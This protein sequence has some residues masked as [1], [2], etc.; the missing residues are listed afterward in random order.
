MNQFPQYADRP[1]RP[2]DQYELVTAAEAR[3]QHHRRPPTRAILFASVCVVIMAAI[4]GW[5]VMT[6]SPARGAAD[7][8]AVPSAQ[9][10]PA[11]PQRKAVEKS[12]PVPVSI[13]EDGMY[14]VGKQIK[15]GRYRATCGARS[16]CIWQR[17]QVLG[18]VTTAVAGGTAM[19]GQTV[20]VELSRGD[21]S[22]GVLGFGEWT[23]Q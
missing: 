11:V 20:L 7:K 13:T 22:F 12:P 17:Y 14:F 4:G 15:A 2:G 21:F 6:D 10:G 19:P 16:T 5:L 9:P 3:Q 18:G 23:I 8:A 1:N